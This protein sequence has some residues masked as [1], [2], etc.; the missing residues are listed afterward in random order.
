MI[1]NAQWR[2]KVIVS[3]KWEVEG[4]TKKLNSLGAERK[5]IESSVAGLLVQFSTTVKNA[6]ETVK[7]QL[8]WGGVEWAKAITQ[9]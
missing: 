4:Y 5:Q 9:N 8:E 1:E 2:E 7:K 3:L 6:G